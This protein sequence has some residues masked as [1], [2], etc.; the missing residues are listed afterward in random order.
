MK[1]L[2][3]GLPGAGKTWLATRL[4]KH[5]DCAWFNADKVR[6]EADDWDFSPEG[7]ARQAERMRS[8]AQAELD[9]GNWV[10]CD[11]VAPT[12]ELRNDFNPD[13]TIWVDTIEEG[14]FEDTNKMFVAPSNFDVRV[15]EHLSDK[16]IKKLADGIKEKIT[17]ENS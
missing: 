9:N 10:I 1:I 6:E 14:R 11:F 8:L 17:R 12:E 5:W 4:Q 2:I 7:R 13:F 15:T 3:M 16:H